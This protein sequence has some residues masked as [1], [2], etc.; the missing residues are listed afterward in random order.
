MGVP[1]VWEKIEEGIKSKA[2]SRGPQKM[3]VVIIITIIIKLIT[4]INIII[5]IIIIVI[6]IIAW[7]HISTMTSTHHGVFCS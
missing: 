7:R 3:V 5:V 1:R 4:I 2:S 6:L